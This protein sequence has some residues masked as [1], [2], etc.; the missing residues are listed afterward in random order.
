MKIYASTFTIDDQI[1][2][3]EDCKT[4]GLWVRCDNLMP[5][6]FGWRGRPFVYICPETIEKDCR[7]RSDGRLVSRVLGRYAYAD[8]FELPVYGF[9]SDTH[10]FYLGEDEGFCVS[11]PLATFTTEELFGI[12]AGA[13]Q[14]A[15]KRFQGKPYWVLA[16]GPYIG[17]TYVKVL[18]TTTKYLYADTISDD[19]VHYE[20][21][22]FS[23]YPPSEMSKTQN[24]SWDNI[25]LYQP[26]DILSED[27]M[28]EL[29]AEADTLYE[30]GPYGE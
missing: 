15:F 8:D 22:S 2:I 21:D 3:L 12:D 28:N 26:I 17:Y 29:L 14:A 24:I 27:E 10:W 18:E 9:T 5:K 11:N 6:N 19:Y 23:E 13:T 16:T 1:Q 7:S 30:E 20:R 4:R 25:Q